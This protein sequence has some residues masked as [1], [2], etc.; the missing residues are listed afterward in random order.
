MQSQHYFKNRYN[1][2]LRRIL[3][4]SHL[5]FSHT[6]ILYFHS[7]NLNEA[8]GIRHPRERP[9][10]D[11]TASSTDI[12][13]IDA[14]HLNVI[15]GLVS[16]YIELEDTE[17]MRGTSMSEKSIIRK[18]QKKSELIIEW[19]RDLQSRRFLLWHHFHLH[20]CQWY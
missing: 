15:E 5:I 16:Y 2:S 11:T 13:S 18:P 14:L 1:L 20:L 8:N 17:G 19:T 12:A 6:V 3:A 7:Q 4:F 10:K 9:S